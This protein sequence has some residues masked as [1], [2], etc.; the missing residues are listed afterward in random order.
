MLV[1]S[2]L[3]VSA[4]GL[5]AIVCL[6]VLLAPDRFLTARRVLT[7]PET[8]QS[9][10]VRLA[11]GDRIRSLL[12][13]RERLRIRACS[14]WPE[15]EAC[16]QECLLQVDLQPQ[17][18]ERTLRAWCEGRDCALCGHPLAP[19]DWRQGRFAG[20][21][22]QGAFVPGAQMSL[23][24]LPLALE[25]YRPVCWNCHC[26]QRELRVEPERVRSAAAWAGE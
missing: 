16:G 15:R 12:A 6:I 7:C 4:V 8:S 3:A 25:N 10:A 22:R 11:I 24:E 26:A 23:S 13:G 17:L 14:R 21:D 1:L 9:V 19:N 2:V 20:V 5:F 18:L